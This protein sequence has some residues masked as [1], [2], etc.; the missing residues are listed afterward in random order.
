MCAYNLIAR[1]GGY[2]RD[3]QIPEAHCSASLA[4]PMSFKFTESLFLKI[5]VKGDLGK[6]SDVNLYPPHMEAST[7]VF[8]YIGI[9]HHSDKC[10]QHTQGERD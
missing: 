7:H 9:H 6:R 10:M 1:I 8:A 4:K 5:K 2:T 3:K